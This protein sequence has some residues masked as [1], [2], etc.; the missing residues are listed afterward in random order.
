MK[1]FFTV[2]RFDAINVCICAKNGQ[3]RFYKRNNKTTKLTLSTSFLYQW[4]KANIY[5]ETYPLR[6]IPGDNRIEYFIYT[7]VSRRFPS[8]EYLTHI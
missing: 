3:C 8:Y 7:P 1:C 2:S 5:Q 6:F 4:V